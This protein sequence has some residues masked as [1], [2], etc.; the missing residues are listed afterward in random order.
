[1]PGYIKDQHTAKFTGPTGYRK[2][3]LVLESIER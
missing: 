1:M 2:S 3:S